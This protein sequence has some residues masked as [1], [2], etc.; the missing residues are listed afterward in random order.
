[1]NTKDDESYTDAKG[2]TRWHRNDE[3]AKNLQQLH[4]ILV[5]GGYEESHATR[6][7]RLAYTISR[8]PE[9]VEALHDEGVCRQ[10]PVSVK[11]LPR[12]SATLSRRA[13]ARS[14]KNSLSTHRKLC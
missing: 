5:I 3:I 7:A 4:D 10:S 6:Y 8:H 9:S 1:M 11:R 2:R 12:L 14:W 13:H